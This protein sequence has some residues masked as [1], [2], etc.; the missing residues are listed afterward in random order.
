M[1]YYDNGNLAEVSKVGTFYYENSSKPYQLT[2]IDLEKESDAPSAIQSISYTCYGRPSRLNENGISASFTYNGDGERVKMLVATGANAVMT[3]Y[4]LGGQY[5]YESSHGETYERLYLGGDYYSAPMMYLRKGEDQPWILYNIGR[6]Y[7]GSITHVA[8]YD[9]SIK[10]E[11]RYD[12][13]G[14]SCDP[15]TLSAYPRGM[16]AMTLTGNRGY[17][18]HEHLPWFGLINMN[19]RLYDP[20]ACRFLSPDPYVQMPDFTQN[21]NRYSYALNN[22]LKYTDQSGEIYWIIPVAYAVTEGIINVVTHLD[23]LHEPW[24]WIAAFGAGAVS[25]ATSAFDPILG[26]TLGNMITGGTNSAIKQYNNGYIDGVQVLTDSFSEMLSGVSSYLSISMLGKWNP[27]GKALDKLK[28]NKWASTITAGGI[29]A[30]IGGMAAGATSASLSGNDFWGETLRTGLSGLAAG[31]TMG[32]TFYSI[33]K[34]SNNTSNVAT[35]DDLSQETGTGIGK[36]LTNAMEPM[37]ATYVI[38]DSRI[39]KTTVF[40]YVPNPINGAKPIQN[41]YEYMNHDYLLK[42]LKGLNL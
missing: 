20:I 4:Y 25:G 15:M 12:A 33:S 8:D 38:C 21:F 40:T 36:I 24:Q 39:G 31:F 30:G 42:I 32:A 7:L 10:E 6:D 41:R 13:W 14:R 26:A 1:A 22:P 18:G 29:Y 28:V 2:S 11:Y 23:D 3:K 34:V 35:I 16:E 27:I 5:E 19:A 37:N 17:T 9:G